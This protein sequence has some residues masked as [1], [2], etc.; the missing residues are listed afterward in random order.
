[1]IC[2][3]SVTKISFWKRNYRRIAGQISFGREKTADTDEP[4]K[5]ASCQSRFGP[6]MQLQPAAARK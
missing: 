6:L 4:A 3:K 1:M 5:W 2:A